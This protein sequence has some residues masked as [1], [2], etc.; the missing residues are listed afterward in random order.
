MKVI[1]PPKVQRD[2]VGLYTVLSSCRFGQPSHEIIAHGFFT[3]D[4]LS[5]DTLRAT[6]ERISEVL[7]GRPPAE[8]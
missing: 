5:A 2:H 6:R 4:E 8:L 3:T 1:V 7:S